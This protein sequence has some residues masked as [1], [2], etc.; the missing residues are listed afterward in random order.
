[1]L[2]ALANKN[3]EFHRPSVKFMEEFYKTDIEPVVGPPILIEIG[4]AVRLRGIDSSHEILQASA[5]YH[6]ELLGL[7]TKRMIELT[8]EY[9]RKK[10]LREKNWLDL[11]HY[12]AATLL[13]CR[14]LVS[15]DKDHFNERVADKINAINSIHSLTSL[16]VGTPSY[17]GRLLAI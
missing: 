14:Y 9:L 16:K 8:D 6:V 2:I 10:T 5:L 3:D 15:W 1:V 4:K 13:E 11:S 17:V 12:A 7:D